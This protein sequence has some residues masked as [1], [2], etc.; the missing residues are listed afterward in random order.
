MNGLKVLSQV[1]AGSAA[2]FAL[3][4]VINHSLSENVVKIRTVKELWSGISGSGFSA[5]KSTMDA[6]T[7]PLFATF[8]TNLSVPVFMLLVSLLLY[9]IYRLILLVKGRDKSARL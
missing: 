2:L 1:M 7:S 3:Y 8:L 9:I 5:F 4:D 6:L